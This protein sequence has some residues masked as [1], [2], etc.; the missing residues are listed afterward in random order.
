M[1]FVAWIIIHGTSN[2]QFRSYCWNFLSNLKCSTPS[3]I[4]FFDTDVFLYWISSRRLDSFY[5]LWTRRQAERWLKG[6]NS[7]TLVH[8]VVF[9]DCR[10]RIYDENPNPWAP[11]GLALESGTEFFIPLDST[12]D[13]DFSES[14]CLSYCTLW[15]WPWLVR[16][17]L[18]KQ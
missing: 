18:W 14:F 13:I 5:R 3:C 7:W 11:W 15:M 1:A 9:P 12:V 16:I 10:S 17:S 6:Q 2:V 4:A 8:K